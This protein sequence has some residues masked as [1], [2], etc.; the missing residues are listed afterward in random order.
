MSSDALEND[1]SIED[2]P[3]W[4][5]RPRFG[6]FWKAS[7]RNVF[8]S[9]PPR[10]DFGVPGAPFWS[11]WDF[12]NIA[13]SWRG[14]SNSSFS[15]FSLGTSPGDKKIIPKRLKLPPQDFQKIPQR[16]LATLRSGPGEPQEAPESSPRELSGDL[17]ASKR[18]PGV[19]VVLGA[20]EPHF[21]APR[22]SFTNLFKLFQTFSSLFSSLFFLSFIVYVILLI[23]LSSFFSRLPSLCSRV[24]SRFSSVYLASLYYWD[25]KIQE[26]VTSR[27]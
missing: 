27:I 8:S 18:S 11:P 2:L 23:F 7:F 20:S 21:G 13:F 22:A 9:E 14:S 4:P 25:F 17:W 26:I 12:K 1:D 24:S 16:S 5:S 10:L 3:L 6:R 15:L 19:G